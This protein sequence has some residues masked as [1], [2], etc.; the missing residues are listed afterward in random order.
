[1]AATTVKAADHPVVKDRQL[2]QQTELADQPRRGSVAMLAERLGT[3]PDGVRDLTE[4]MVRAALLS[5]P[6]DGI[7]FFADYLDAE[8]KR[9][10]Q[11]SLRRG[12]LVID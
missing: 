7:K 8:L 1:M 11:H 6:T 2:W 9:R 3:T 4:K 5:R 10:S 12:G